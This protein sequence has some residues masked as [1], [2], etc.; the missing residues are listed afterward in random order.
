MN[1][2]VHKLAAPCLAI[3]SSLSVPGCSN[4]ANESGAGAAPV[5]GAAVNA[6]NSQEEFFKQQQEK[7]AQEKA[8]KAR[9]SGRPAK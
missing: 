7:T 9:K 5:G 6:P 8:A 2:W 3:L 4:T 1:C